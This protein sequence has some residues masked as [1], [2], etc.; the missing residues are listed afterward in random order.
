MLPYLLN[1]TTF[2]MPSQKHFGIRTKNQEKTRQNE[3]S[4]LQ[5]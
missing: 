4:L 5:A 3:T 2:L 1:N